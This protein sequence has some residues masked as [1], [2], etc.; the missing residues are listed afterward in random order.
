MSFDYAHRKEQLD[1]PCLVV[2]AGMA[3]DGLEHFINLIPK[4]LVHWIKS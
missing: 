2:A 4:P 3:W 1:R